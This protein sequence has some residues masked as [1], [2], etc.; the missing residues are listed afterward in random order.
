MVRKVRGTNGT[1][2]PRMVRKVYGTNRPWYEKSTNGTKRLWYE[3]SMVRKVRHPLFDTPF[4]G[5]PTTIRIYLTLQ[6]TKLLGYIF[7]NRGISISFRAVAR[8][9]FNAK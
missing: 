6:E 3:K 9:D 7:S 1:K 2:S 8:T 4:L 5:N